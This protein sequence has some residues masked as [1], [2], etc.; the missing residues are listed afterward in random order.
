MPDDARLR[1]HAGAAVARRPDLAQSA[2]FT[3]CSDKR[4]SFDRFLEQHGLGD[5]LTKIVIPAAEPGDP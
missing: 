4:R 3:L 2:A 1:L 5:T